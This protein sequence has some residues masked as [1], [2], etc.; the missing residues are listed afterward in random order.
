MRLCPGGDLGVPK[1]FEWLI[2]LRQIEK[3]YYI[4]VV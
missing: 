2:Y 1:T 3:D 4:V